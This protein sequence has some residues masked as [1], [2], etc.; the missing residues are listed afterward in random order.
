MIY[1]VDFG[2]QT[3]HLIERRIRDLGALTRLI[4]PDEVM[5]AI[6]NEK[7][8]GIILSGGPASVYDSNSP[9]L[10]N[11]IFS[12]N[13]PLLAICYGMQ[14]MM[15]LLGGTVVSGKKEYGPSVLVRTSDK[16]KLLEGIPHQSTVWMSHGDEVTALPQGFETLASTD[17]VEYACVA[18][19]KKGLLG[20]LF[21]PEVEHT[22]YGEV[23]LKNFVALCNTPLLKKETPLLKPEEELICKNCG[24]KLSEFLKISK[25]KCERCYD[26]FEPH[27]MRII[28][29]YHK[30]KEHKGKVY[31]GIY[32]ESREFK[33]K[34]LKRALDEAI[35]RE[36]YERAARL[37]DLI[38]EI[39]GKDDA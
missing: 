34:V 36:E 26:S 22:E 13:I 20:M 28:Y 25:F 31:T 37:R 7:P 4:T 38:N 33:L 30:G 3:A 8:H 24:Y 1:I 9:T 12:M 6:Q 27:T 21:H 35:K 11:K 32:K 15:H 17:R 29:E 39:E 23:I 19:P 2:S 16:G 18:N 10:E 14:L 5:A